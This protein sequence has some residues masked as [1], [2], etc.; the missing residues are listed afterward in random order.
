MAI[1]GQPPETD[2]GENQSGS[3]APRETTTGARDGRATP[4][5][6]SHPSLPTRYTSERVYNTG[7]PHRLSGGMHLQRPGEIGSDR[8]PS[9]G[10]G[11]TTYTAETR[12]RDGLEQQRIE[13]SVAAAVRVE[14]CPWRHREQHF[15]AALSV[16][17]GA[18]SR[19]SQLTSAREIQPGTAAVIGVALNSAVLNLAR[20]EL[21]GAGGCSSR[22]RVDD[23]GGMVW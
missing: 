20:N 14:S 19:G 18:G 13:E 5:P 1:H 12:S 11:L 17:G 10:P 6:S 9:P 22:G 15:H 23:C 21:N 3:K 4:I 16:S 7:G 2:Q 8:R